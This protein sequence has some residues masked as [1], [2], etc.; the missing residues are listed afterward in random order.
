[1]FTKLPDRI[2]NFFVEYTKLAEGY[3]IKLGDF[4][5]E[6]HNENL[7]IAAK[8][9]L[10][11]GKDFIIENAIEGADCKNAIWRALVDLVVTDFIESL[12]DFQNDHFKNSVNDESLGA[13]VFDQSDIDDIEDNLKDSFNGGDDS[14]QKFLEPFTLEGIIALVDQNGQ[15]SVFKEVLFAN[16]AGQD[17][18]LTMGDL[19]DK[20][21]INAH[22]LIV[23]L[24]VTPPKE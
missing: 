5:I 1:M 9:A 23:G 7:A 24:I 15:G 2:E 14:A 3:R 8:N 18:D 19:V 16:C 22:R 11:A 21:V 6:T 17:R 20:L 4:F 10:Q 13:L 12:L